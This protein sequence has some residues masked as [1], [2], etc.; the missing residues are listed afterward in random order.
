MEDARLKKIE[1]DLEEIKDLIKGARTLDEDSKWVYTIKEAH[2]SLG[3]SRSKLVKEMKAGKIR[4]YKK[5]KRILILKRE[6]I[7]DIVRS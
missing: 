6:L 7:E 1:D 3:W 4:Y 5:G 2:Q